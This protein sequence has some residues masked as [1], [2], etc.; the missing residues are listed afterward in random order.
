MTSGGSWT[1]PQYVG[2][3][4]DPTGLTF[5]VTYSDGTAPALV[6]PQAHTPTTWG[7]TAGT[8]VCTFTYTEGGET[9]S[10]EVEATVAEQVVL[11]GLSVTGT[12]AAQYTGHAPDLT[13]LTFKAVYSD[14]SEESVDAADIVVSPA[15]WTE[16]GSATLT[17]SYTEDETTVSE[18]V[19]VTVTAD[20][21]VSITA[22]G[23]DSS[24]QI[25]G[26]A[27]VLTGV[28]LTG[29]KASGDTVSVALDDSDLTI[30]P[31]TW[32]ASG[33]P[34]NLGSQTLT[35][36]LD[37]DGTD[38]IDEVSTAVHWPANPTLDMDTAGWVYMD[39]PQEMYSL[40]SGHSGSKWGPAGLFQGTTAQVG[41]LAFFAFTEDEYENDTP[42]TAATLAS[43]LPLYGLGSQGETFAEVGTPNESGF[44]PAYGVQAHTDLDDS[45]V[46]VR[47]DGTATMP[48]GTEDCYV[49]FGTL[50]NAL[51][52]TSYKRSDLDTTET[53][54]TYVVQLEKS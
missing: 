48:S 25:K 45:Y 39:M 34:D 43:W 51:D 8:Q 28:T 26:S 33:N 41:D 3:P 29:T 14:T 50:A 44:K 4:V 6:S 11:S 32:D 35:F 1:N 13:G 38:V 9:V 19:S 49:M 53:I 2:E 23:L 42:V 27:P 12:P 40:I 46:A 31:A 21:I 16:A 37:V 30:T 18:N 54:W 36:T 15:T 47:T 5:T 22:T 20:S 52:G 17:C 7:A 10:C 24:L